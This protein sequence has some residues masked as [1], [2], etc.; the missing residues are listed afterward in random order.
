MRRTIYGFSVLAL[1]LAGAA[2]AQAP[3]GFGD[4]KAAP[5]GV[6]RVNAPSAPT[7]PGEMSLTNQAWAMLGREDR[8]FENRRPV[9]DIAAEDAVAIIARQAASAQIVII[10]E[11]HDAP[12]HRAFIGDVAEA[13]QPLGFRIYAGE[14][15]SPWAGVGGANGR[16]Y[17]ILAD[18]HYV[19]EPAFGMLMRR[20]RG[21]GYSF[22]AYEYMGQP[23]V[24]AAD[25][26]EAL[27]TREAGQ[28]ANLVQ[29]IFARDADARVLI[30]VG[31]QHNLETTERVGAVAS[32]RRREIV[33][34]A[35]RL[36]D[37]LGIDPLTI[38]QT[39]FAASQTGVCIGTGPG[40]GLPEGRDMY[41]A[42]TERFITQHRAEWR[43]ARGEVFVTLPSGLAPADARAVYEARRA[44]EPDEAVPIDRVLVDPGEVVAMMLPP[45][46]YRVRAWSEERG[47]SRNVAVTA[48][49]TKRPTRRKKR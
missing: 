35:R 26:V 10:N 45:G 28:T 6:E 12:M 29:R 42:H 16:A 23:S 5:N 38:D 34:M 47:W 32:L 8:I 20:L 1:I 15:L 39:T 48:G 13:L 43:R 22:V 18:G 4:P 46:R 40:G 3:S 25:F 44:E 41:V 14:A 33:W 49:E 11:A 21:A 2:L 9:C 7:T 17:P 19:Q 36:K 37:T 24:Q 31:H 27:N 30:H